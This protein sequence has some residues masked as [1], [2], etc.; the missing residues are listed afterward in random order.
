MGFGNGLDSWLLRR[1]DFG[2]LVEVDM[3]LCRLEVRVDARIWCGMV[4]RWHSWV[5][6]SLVG[7]SKTYSVFHASGL[8]EYG[9]P[10]DTWMC[11]GYMDERQRSLRR[12]NVYGICRGP[13]DQADVA[14][15]SRL[16]GL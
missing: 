5:D 6:I 16:L 8:V 12:G 11:L 9:K 4:M 1:F 15:S 7:K 3:C 13:T 2:D 14:G 10:D